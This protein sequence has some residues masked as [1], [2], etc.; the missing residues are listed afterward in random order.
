MVPGQKAE[1][2]EI[3]LFRIKGAALGG[4]SFSTMATQFGAVSFISD[5]YIHL[6]SSVSVLIPNNYC[7]A[8]IL[9]YILMPD[10]GL[11]RHML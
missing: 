5:P 11:H 4:V 9:V 1:K 2:P 7:S 8:I 3:L 6:E 10:N